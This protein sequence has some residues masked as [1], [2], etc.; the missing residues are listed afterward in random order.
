M[1]SC[2]ERDIVLKALILS[3]PACTLFAGA[4]VLSFRSRSVPSLLQLL[5]AG[6][7]IVVVL[8]HDAD[9]LDLFSGMGWGIENSIGEAV[10]SF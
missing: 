9:A 4:A 1:G 2:H 5:G 10:E 6:C 7:L 3:V 8:T